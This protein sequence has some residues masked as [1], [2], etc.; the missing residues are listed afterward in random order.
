[1][2]EKKELN[3]HIGERIHKARENAS[4]TQEKLAEK[5]EVSV[6]Y[7]SDLERG[8]VGTSIQTLIKICHALSVSSDY[9]LMGY[10][11]EA[12]PL[13]LSVRLQALSPKERKLME[14][15][16]NLM[17]DAFHVNDDTIPH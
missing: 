11:A 17:L 8:V 7:I 3:I 4:Y 6:Q 16:I 5:I 2:K 12:E 10:S 13:D 9:I 14:A 1:M 15:N